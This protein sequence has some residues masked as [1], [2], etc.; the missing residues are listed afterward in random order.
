H[1]ASMICCMLARSPGAR[2]RFVT[3]AS[4]L[5][6]AVITPLLRGARS[7]PQRLVICLQARRIISLC[8]ILTLSRR[9]RRLARGSS[10]GGRMRREPEADRQGDAADRQMR[11]AGEQALRK[12]DV[13]ERAEAVDEE[14]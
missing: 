6:A 7:L 2:T 4:V 11:R 13:V 9:K 12:L 3:R 8:G 10:R 14:A 1:T 5:M